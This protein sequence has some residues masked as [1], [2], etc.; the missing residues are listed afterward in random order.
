MYIF[1]WHLT[2]TECSKA[3][4]TNTYQHSSVY[5]CIINNTFIIHSTLISIDVNTNWQTNRN[6][7][8]KTLTFK[9]MIVKLNIINIYMHVLIRIWIYSQHG[10]YMYWASDYRAHISEWSW[11]SFEG[12][13][14][15]PV[16]SA[17]TSWGVF[18]LPGVAPNWVTSGRGAP[19]QGMLPQCPFII[20]LIYFHHINQIIIVLESITYFLLL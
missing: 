11:P 5:V 10:K 19:G 3:G 4:H 12:L 8:L 13:S 14:G 18:D 17:V 16:V 15:N 6:W 20:L 9:C 1:R 7:N 2:F